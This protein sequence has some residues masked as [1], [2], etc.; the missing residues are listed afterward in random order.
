[1]RPNAG[2]GN[3]CGKVTQG[4]SDGEEDEEAETVHQGRRPDAEDHGA[5]EDEDNRDRT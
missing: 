1:M 2:G 5:R 4:Q 3:D